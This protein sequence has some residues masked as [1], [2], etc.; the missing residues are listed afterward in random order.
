MATI[1]VTTRVNDF[2]AWTAAFDKNQ[3]ARREHGWI[4]HSVHRDAAD[5]KV[6]VVVSRVH[7]LARARAFLTSPEVRAAMAGVS[8]GG[9]PEVKVLDDV[10]AHTY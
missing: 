3:S 1:I 5:P 4:A 7:D 10:S 8:T 2:E 6:V 9:P